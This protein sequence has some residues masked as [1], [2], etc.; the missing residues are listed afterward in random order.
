MCKCDIMAKKIIGGCYSHRPWVLKLWRSKIRS[1]FNIPQRARQFPG[2]KQPL[3]TFV[4]MSGALAKGIR[5]ELLSIIWMLVE[6]TVSIAAGIAACSA[7]LTAF[8]IDSVIELIT[9]GVLLWRLSKEAVSNDAPATARAERFARWVVA[10][11]L[12]L[13]CLYVLATSLYGLYAHILPGHSPTGILISLAAVVG[14]PWLAGQKKRIAQEIN[15]K[16]LTGDAACSIVCAYMAGTVLLGLVLN[17]LFH[18]WW[19]EHIA[20][21]LFLYWLVKETKEAFDT[22]RKKQVSCGCC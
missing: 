12:G 7:L 20:G 5:I 13:L 4:K 8:G 14:M 15:S 11:A 1:R 17:Y 21:L 3:R 2:D 16:A 19:A 22:L 18:W 9:A 6:A 10:L